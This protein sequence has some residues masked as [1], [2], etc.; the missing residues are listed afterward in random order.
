MKDPNKLLDDIRI[1]SPC[2]ASWDAMTGTDTVRFCG[3]CKLN[4]YNLSEMQ[5]AE[6]ASLVEKAEGRVCVRLYKRTDGTV[7]T[8]NC[9]VGLRATLARA[10]RA[11]GAT[12]AA[13]LGLFS[14]FVA[15]P[16]FAGEPQDRRA[17]SPFP[18]SGDNPQPIVMGKIAM[19][20]GDVSVSV[21]DES[22]AAIENATVTLVDPKTSETF[23]AE[24][25]ADSASFRFPYVRPGV[26][27]LNVSA[28]AFGSTTRRAI[29]VRQGQPV[30]LEV[31]LNVAIMGEIV[32]VPSCIE[33]EP[34]MQVDEEPR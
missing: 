8:R 1:A 27:E 19:P 34:L 30:R 11:A 13:V 2:T 24:Y 22:G 33:P 26:F 4:V 10:S 12:L 28:P 6:A 7:L 31:E 23:E 9:P 17:S 21:V 15:R 5:A 3:E 25:D 14:G 16:S 29:R 32:N 20:R 18:Q